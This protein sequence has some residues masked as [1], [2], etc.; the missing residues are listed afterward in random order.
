MQGLAVIYAKGQGRIQARRVPWR[1]SLAVD[2]A[3]FMEIIRRV[4]QGLRSPSISRD[5][6][7]FLSNYQPGMSW[8]AI[9][10][11]ESHLTEDARYKDTNS[12]VSGCTTHRIRYEVKAVHAMLEGKA[13]KSII[14]VASKEG[15]FQE[16]GRIHPTQKPVRIMQRLMDIV[17]PDRGVVCDPFMGSGSTGVAAVQTHRPFIGMELDREYYHGARR[18]IARAIQEGQMDL[19]APT[20]DGPCAE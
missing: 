2:P 20:G 14:A 17:C 11:W 16:G 18:R 9:P 5:I 15:N 19:F 6:E 4:D 3:S 12:T 8:K 7:W 1:E 10:G 13:E